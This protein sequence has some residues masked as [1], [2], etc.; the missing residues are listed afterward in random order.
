MV[1]CAR[2]RGRFTRQ[3]YKGPDGW[4]CA[5]CEVERLRAEL[6]ELTRLAGAV[7]DS[8]EDPHELYDAIEALERTFIL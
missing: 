8:K 7:V 4:V 6:T 2:C 5:P 1:V 3:N